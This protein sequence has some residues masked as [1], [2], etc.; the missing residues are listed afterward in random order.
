MNLFYSPGLTDHT[1]FTLSSEESH[2]A[3]RVLR[4]GLGDEIV[5]VN[6]EGGWYTAR[7]LSADPKACQ[8]EITDRQQGLGKPNYNLHVAMAPTKQIDRFEWFIE[9]ATEIGISEITPLLSDRSERK[10]VKTDRLM[11]IVI[12]AMKQSLKA[13]HPII[14]PQTS[15]KNLLAQNRP[16]ALLIAHCQEGEKLWLDESIFS[17]ESITILIGPEGDF[18]PD[19]IQLAVQ[20]KYQPVTL[21]VSR[22][23]TE[24]AGLVAVQ[25]VSWLFR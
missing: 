25:T 17:P 7:I 21:G 22:L 8:V 2:H 13:F 24:T 5:L 16:G 3:V 12:A 4:M 1:E 14:H 20:N 19:E 18:S 10:D 6:G 11:R 9:K 23:R 15:F